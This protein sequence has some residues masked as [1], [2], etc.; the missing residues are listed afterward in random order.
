MK[1]NTH[2]RLDNDEMCPEC[3][4]EYFWLRTTDDLGNSAYECDIC[5]K[6]IL[7]DDYGT[8]ILEEFIEMFQGE[9]EKQIQEIHNNTIR[10][11]KRNDIRREH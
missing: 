9:H 2:N 6:V 4:S 5:D 10:M 1:K 7:V 8:I 11:M 3:N